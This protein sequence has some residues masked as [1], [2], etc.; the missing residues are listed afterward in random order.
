MMSKERLI[1]FT[2][3]ILAI[4]MTILVTRWKSQAR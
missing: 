2:A 1:A 4:I 3:A